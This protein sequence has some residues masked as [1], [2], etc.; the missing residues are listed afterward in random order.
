MRVASGWNIYR[1]VYSEVSVVSL[2]LLI[3]TSLVLALFCSS[4]PTFLFINPR[5]ACTARAIQYVVVSCVCVCVCVCV[6]LSLKLSYSKVRDSV[7]SL[8]YS[9]FVMYCV[10]GKPCSS[11]LIEST[12]IL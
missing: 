2:I 3:P 7:P 6:C 10:N 1:Y 5:H 8:R 4:I 9:P 11:G 12:Y